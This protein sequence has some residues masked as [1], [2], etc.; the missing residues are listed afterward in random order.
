MSVLEA[1]GVAKQFGGLQAVAGV[2]LAVADGEVVGLFGPNGAGKTTL[3]N[4]M[5]GALVPDAG[6]VHLHG[7]NVTR[8]PAHR[9]ARLGLARTFQIVQPLEHLSVADNLLVPLA[10]RPLNRLLPLGRYHRPERMERVRELLAQVG[11]G[12]EQD[13]PA[14]RLPL[15]MKKRLEVARALALEPKVLLLDE[16]LAGL[17]HQDARRL[18]ELIERVG[19]QIGVVLV[20][21]NVRLAMSACHR[22]VVMEAGVLIAAGPPEDVRRDPNVIRAYLGEEADA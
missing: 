3:F 12:R 15:G 4:L 8:L 20:E 6:S 11:L 5:A 22:A 2:D 17:T 19:H 16:P 1:L 10:H 7:R 14:G 9:R 18:L 21:H 13:T